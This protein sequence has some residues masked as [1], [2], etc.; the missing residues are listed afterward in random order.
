MKLNKDAKVW[1]KLWSVQLNALGAILM[2][3]FT[4]WPDSILYLWTAMP[5]EVKQLI[6]QQFVTV[7]A[8]AI[9]ALS[10]ISRV[11]KQKKLEQNESK[12]D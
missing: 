5:A 4:A 9:F 7:L 6:P 8:C 1:W 11:L 12:A 2:A 3:F 10:S